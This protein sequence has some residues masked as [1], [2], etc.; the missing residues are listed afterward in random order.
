MDRF[1]WV[2]FNTH[3]RQNTN[4][5]PASGHQKTTP[6]KN[7]KSFLGKHERG[8]EKKKSVHQVQGNVELDEQRKA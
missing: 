3:H 5:L 1:R 4:W 6:K 8:E 2:F 7:C